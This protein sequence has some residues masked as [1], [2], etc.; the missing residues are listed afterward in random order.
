M[1]RQFA[2]K[3][4]KVFFFP[5]KRDPFPEG[6]QI[7]LTLSLLKVNHFPLSDILQSVGLIFTHSGVDLINDVFLRLSEDKAIL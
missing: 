2:S 7:F 1:K 4:I 3:G 6:R 5:F